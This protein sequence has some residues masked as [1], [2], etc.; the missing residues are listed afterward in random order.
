ME[1]RAGPEDH[2]S[3][4]SLIADHIYLFAGA[5]EAGVGIAN[6][7]ASAIAAEKG[8][9]LEDARACIWL[10]DSEGLVTAERLRESWR[11]RVVDAHK[12]PY[13]H[14]APAARVDGEE[15]NTP[16]LSAIKALKP[17]ALIGVSAQAGIFTEA[18]CREMAAVHAAALQVSRPSSPPPPLLIFALSNPTSKAEC[19]AAEAY[20][21]TGSVMSTSIFVLIVRK[22]ASL[23][24]N[25]NTPC[26][27]TDYLC[28]FS[29]PFSYL[30]GKAIF[31]SGSPFD[32]LTVADGTKRIPGQGN[33]A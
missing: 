18:V 8:C 7:L 26:C 33:N 14:E 11:G 27:I 19:T 17:T 2:A 25:V 4:A 20:E 29:S 21:W 16:L 1:K 3:Y 6:L 23:M 15:T 30:R 22:D 12:V 5:G 9:S 24:P 32:P 10:T 13:A 31:A 28:P